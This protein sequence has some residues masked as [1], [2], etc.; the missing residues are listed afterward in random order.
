MSV[1][2]ASTGSR[3]A[4]HLAAAGLVAALGLAASSGC[5]SLPPP[6]PVKA[7]KPD[8]IILLSFE[9]H[10]TVARFCKMVGPAFSA[11]SDGNLV[12]AFIE[13]S[14]SSTNTV[15]GVGST[16]GSSGF[17]GIAYKCP[18]EVVLSLTEDAEEPSEDD[19]KGDEVA[20]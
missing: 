8:P 16:V 4:H 20:R 10:L 17:Q 9:N 3:R 19:A 1:A 5:I 12:V 13:T 11:Y 15:N 6:V 7:S 18:K 14:A 2:H